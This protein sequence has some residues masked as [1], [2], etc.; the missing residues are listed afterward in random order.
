MELAPNTWYAMADVLG[1]PA[2]RLGDG[3]SLWRGSSRFCESPLEALCG[4]IVNRY[5]RRVEDENGQ[6]FEYDE[7]W[8]PYLQLTLQD[9]D[10]AHLAGFPPIAAVSR[11]LL[12]EHLLRLTGSRYAWDIHIRKDATMYRGTGAVCLRLV[13]NGDPEAVTG[14]TRKTREVDTAYRQGLLDDFT[15]SKADFRLHIKPMIRHLSAL[16]DS[17][18]L[19]NDTWKADVIFAHWFKAGANKPLL[20]PIGPDDTLSL[21]DLKLRFS[22]RFAQRERGFRMTDLF[23][24]R[25]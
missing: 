19:P 8:Q 20:S 5:R 13:L 23:K 3:S 18:Y 9:V 2:A 6:H 12:R 4:H 10:P 16:Q 14:L 24:A 1:G 15:R 22:P 17:G 11:R 7:Q 21:E 25:Y